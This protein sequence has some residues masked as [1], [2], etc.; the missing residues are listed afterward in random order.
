MKPLIGR[1]ITKYVWT[2]VDVVEGVSLDEQAANF[3]GDTDPYELVY[4]EDFS[5][6]NVLN[7]ELAEYLETVPK[8]VEKP[9]FGGVL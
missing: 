3:F 1:R 6:Y 5:Q 2:L 4:A 8:P 7:S 9:K